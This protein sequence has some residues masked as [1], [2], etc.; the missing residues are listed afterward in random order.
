MNEHSDYVRF[1]PESGH[2]DTDVCFSADFV[3]FTPVN[4]HY[5]DTPICPFLT[6]NG[7]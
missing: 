1:T 5:S 2:A 7:H 6:L 3:R 4:G